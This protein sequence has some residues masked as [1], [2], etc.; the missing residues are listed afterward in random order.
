MK[1]QTRHIDG[2]G[3]IP[4]VHEEISGTMK[5]PKNRRFQ[6][7]TQINIYKPK[8]RETLMKSKIRHL[9]DEV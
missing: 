9:K 1:S 3:R 7:G 5:C 8:Y 2:G 6:K 4:R